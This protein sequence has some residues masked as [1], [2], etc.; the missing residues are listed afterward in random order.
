MHHV[1]YALEDTGLLDVDN[2]RPIDVTALHLT[3]MPRINLVLHEFMEAFNHHQL[4]T[5]NHW[6]PYQMWINGMLNEFNPLACGQLDDHP[7]DLEYYGIDPN[8]PTPFE[9]SDNNVVLPSVALPVDHQLVNSN[10]L[11]RIDPLMSS[12]LMG[13]DIY[14]SV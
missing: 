13:I 12:T 9:N 4:R 1:F 10:V 8:G 7:Q 2:P 5:A 6:S 14:T 3:F 11:E